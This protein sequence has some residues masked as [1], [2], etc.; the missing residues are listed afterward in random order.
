MSQRRSHTTCGVGAEV[1]RSAGKFATLRIVRIDGAD[2]SDYELSI[3]HV[4]GSRLTAPKF[5]MAIRVSQRSM[6]F[7]AANFNF[8]LIFFLF[9]SVA[10]ASPATTPAAAPAPAEVRIRR[11][12]ILPLLR[13]P[14]RSPSDKAVG[15]WTGLGWAVLDKLLILASIS[16]PLFYFNHHLATFSLFSSINPRYLHTPPKCPT[17]LPSTSSRPPEPPSVRFLGS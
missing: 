6:L 16:L 5:I 2:L 14:A 12:N 11:Q 13:D 10:H 8:Y 17:F 7:R 9:F 4:Y 15:T 1:P 3:A